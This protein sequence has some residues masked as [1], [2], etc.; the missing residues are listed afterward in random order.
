MGR[1]MQRNKAAIAFGGLSDP[2]AKGV[3]AEDACESQLFAKPTVDGRP[4]AIPA[5]HF[6]VSGL[7]EKHAFPVLQRVA[8]IQQK[9]GPRFI[10]DAGEVFKVR[11][12][13]PRSAMQSGSTISSK[14]H[15]YPVAQYF[16][17]GFSATYGQ[18]R[19]T[20]RHGSS[21]GGSAPH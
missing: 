7:Q 5:F 14:D 6:G 1:R 3:G 21:P 13:T 2:A 11:I 10:A 12:G 19:W 16:E 4:S 15:R 9:N 20:N 17:D 18:L 8:W